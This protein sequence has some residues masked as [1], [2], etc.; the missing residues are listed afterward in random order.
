MASIWNLIWSVERYL[1]EIAQMELSTRRLIGRFDLRIPIIL[2]L[3]MKTAFEPKINLT[4]NLFLLSLFQFQ[5]HTQHLNMEWAIW[6][7]RWSIREAFELAG[8]HHLNTLTTVRLK[9]TTW[10]TE[11]CQMTKCSTKRSSSAIP[12]QK[13]YW[14]PMTIRLPRVPIHLHCPC[15]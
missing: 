8:C 15:C 11:D 13:V 6:K 5:T 2:N 12:V 3:L 7:R 4:F 14:I 1:L 9:A 10:A